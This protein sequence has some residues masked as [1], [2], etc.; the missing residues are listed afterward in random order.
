M[1]NYAVEQINT[2][3]KSYGLE[4][5]QVLP[6]QIR[7]IANKF[8]ENGATGKFFVHQQDIVLGEEYT[9]VSMLNKVL[10]EL[11]HFGG[12]TAI[13]IDRM[14]AQRDLFVSAYR[15]GLMVRSRENNSQDGPLAYLNG[16][17]EAVTEELSNRMC[18]LV[19]DEHHV[20]GKMLTEHDV[21]L[22]KLISENRADL[23]KSNFREHWITPVY[24][25]EKLT[26]YTAYT[27]ERLV[28]FSLFQKIH[29]RTER[30][31]TQTLE[32]TEE[33]LFE[34]LTKAYFTGNI[35][36]FGRLFNNT[37]GRG[38]FREYG[39]LQTVEEQKAFID[40]L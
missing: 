11:T 28:M 32:E 23:E 1:I 19:P 30:G 17:N 15:M 25:N 21:L 14:P 6:E 27:G 37:F 40:A 29:N 22:E 24:V 18:S 35:L 36:P 3:R 7:F 12:Y 38:K 10:H 13:Q 4:G 9:P 31:T 8:T 39:Q 26:A 20:F 5:I 33:E 16:L 2:L 34:M